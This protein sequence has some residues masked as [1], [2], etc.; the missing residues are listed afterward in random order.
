[1]AVLLDWNLSPSPFI[2]QVVDLDLLFAKDLIRNMRTD[3]CA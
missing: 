2:G 1:M 3:S